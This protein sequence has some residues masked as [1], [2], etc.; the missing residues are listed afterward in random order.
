M[1]NGLGS[2][3]SYRAYLPG[4]S[5]AQE[6]VLHRFKLV[7]TEWNTRINLISR[8]DI[9]LFEVNHVVHSLAIARYIRF[10]PGAEVM[11]LGTGGGFPGIPLSIVFPEAQFTLVDS[12][13]KK[14]GAVTA[15]VGELGLQN[16]KVVRA[17]VEELDGRV[18]YVVSRAV[19]PMEDLVLWTKRILAP[20]QRGS[21][22][23]GWVVLKGGD[24]KQE[25]S[26]FSKNIEI[27]CIRDYWKD[28]FFEAKKIVYL[29]RQLV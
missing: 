15:M 5:P 25:L 23:N 16:V 1:S 26:R 19:A 10:N 9:D 3:F 11:D 18:D 6:E 24:L 28:D 29:P 17:R 12:I 27:K 4:L 21:L 22:P 13:A 20:G 7:F 8:K 2:S 14:T